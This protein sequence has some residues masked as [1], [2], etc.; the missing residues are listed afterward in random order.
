MNRMRRNGAVPVAPRASLTAVG[1]DL[2]EITHSDLEA[3]LALHTTPD[4]ERFVGSVQ[5]SL[6]DA[7]S[8]PIANPWYRAVYVDGELVGF[9][10]I[11]WNAEPRPPEIIGP[12]F[13]VEAPDR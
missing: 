12:W 6:Q 8:Y 9:V 3:V 5:Q 10:M 4:Q 11:S 2:V 1:V 13:P 7:A